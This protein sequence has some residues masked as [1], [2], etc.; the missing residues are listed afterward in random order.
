MKKTALIKAGH[1]WKLARSLTKKYGAPSS[2]RVLTVYIDH[3]DNGEYVKVTISAVDMR[4]SWFEKSQYPGTTTGDN[5]RRPYK[6]LVTDLSDLK[7]KLEFIA[8]NYGPNGY[9]SITDSY[10]FVD[11][12]SGFSFDMRPETMIGEIVSI[13]GPIRPVRDM[14]DFE[15]LKIFETEIL[16]HAHFDGLQGK[17]AQNR[18]LEYYLVPTGL[19]FRLSPRLADFCKMNGMANVFHSNP[20]KREVIQRRSNDYSH[21]GN[22]FQGF[23]GVD[24]LSSDEHYQGE[25][26]A[27]A[28][29][30]I[31]IPYYNSA[32]T[33]HKVLLGL[34]SQDAPKE[35][36][37][38][39]EVII[40][41]DA[42]GK[43]ASSTVNQKEYP[44]GVKLVTLSE[45]SG[46][47]HAR[48]IGVVHSSGEILIFLDSDIVVSSSY[49]RDHVIRNQV[50]TNSVF[51]SFKQDIDRSSCDISDDAIEIGL[52]VGDISR[53]SRTARSYPVQILNSDEEYSKEANMLEE[54]FYFK[55]FH[56]SQKI[57][58]F[59]LSGM[60]VGHNFS[61]RRDLVE[62]ARPFSRR[63]KG[64]G[65]ED[66]Y[67]GIQ[68]LLANAYI[69]PVLSSSVYHLDHPPRSG[70]HEAKAEEAKRNKRIV[71]EVL[72]EPLYD[73]R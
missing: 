56:G 23:S 30:S 28:R 72:D 31:I 20:S 9:V 7:S 12:V 66:A 63:F 53:E 68:M 15:L 29:V 64:W 18:Q 19:G 69:I 43:S 21:W 44:F 6:S 42:S 67:T 37:E 39:L 71:E 2:E 25:H 10:R 58:L 11:E 45:N 50:I 26:L 54:T 62:R 33:I 51:V 49:I 13:E 5:G 70:S 52:P 38:N 36:I 48:Q 61:T 73:T 27:S 46:A 16:D 8:R 65:M 41:D 22:F 47:A 1:F 55:N 59:E 24:L 4:C 60:I 34:A 40:V 32:E 35:L 14:H 57:G 17:I 3:E